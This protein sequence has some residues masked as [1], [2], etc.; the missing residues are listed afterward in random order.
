[1]KKVNKR[2][3]YN[4]DHARISLISGVHEGS[5]TSPLAWKEPEQQSE[6]EIDKQHL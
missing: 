2:K 5:S 3:N 6:L 1:M 4:T